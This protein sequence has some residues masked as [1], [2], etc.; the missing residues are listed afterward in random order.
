MNAARIILVVTASM[1]SPTV[2][3]AQSRGGQPTRI[4]TG[5]IPPSTSAR[6]PVGGVIRGN[7]PGTPPRPPMVRGFVYDSAVVEDDEVLL[8]VA[9]LPM[10]WQYNLKGGAGYFSWRI[11]VGEGSGLGIVLAADTMMRSTNINRMVEGSTLRRCAN[12]R[13]LS[14]RRCVSPIANAEVRQRENHIQFHLKDSSIVNF[15]RKTRPSHLT[16]TA[17]EP[18]GRFRVDVIPI[19]YHDGIKTVGPAILKR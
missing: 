16:G 11:D 7:P 8:L 4:P 5:K 17:Y 6:P 14:S 10:R 1:L 19:A 9:P 3:I 13:E 18:Q 15:F 12:P 2:V